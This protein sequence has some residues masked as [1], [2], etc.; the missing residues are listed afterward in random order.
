MDPI[1]I[2]LDGLNTAIYAGY[3]VTGRGG[4]SGIPY[5]ARH[6]VALGY[7]PMSEVICIRKGTVCFSGDTL[8]FWA[9]VNYV[10]TDNKSV[11]RKKYVPFNWKDN[12]DHNNSGSNVP[13]P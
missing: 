9:S 2:E 1:Y 11:K 4:N 10:E 5:M 3:S 7:D 6:L 8:D 12:D 13:S